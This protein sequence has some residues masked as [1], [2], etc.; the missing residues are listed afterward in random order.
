MKKRS[1]EARVGGRAGKAERSRRRKGPDTRRAILDAA[2]QRLADG[3][4]E[5]IR[6]QEIAR[7]VGIS[8][9]A[10]LHHFGSREGLTQALAQDAMDRLSTEVLEV[11]SRPADE[12]TAL[13]IVRRIFDTWGDSGHA[14]LFAWR[15]LDM[16]EPRP[17]HSEQEMIRVLTD[18]IHTRRVEHARERGLEIPSREDSA[19]LV[20]L[21]AVALLGDAVAGGI[22]DFR[23]RLDGQRDARRRFRAWLTELLV[24]HLVPGSERD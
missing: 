24:E 15:S 22:F 3:G 11:L 17:E 7:D 6:L 20:R 5:A 19:F 13:D 14:R 8:H 1:E 2:R 9:P 18:A 21:T 12:A 10:I 23:A 16:D 4:P